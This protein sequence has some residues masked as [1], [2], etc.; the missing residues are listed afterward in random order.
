MFVGDYSI[1]WLYKYFIDHLKSQSKSLTSRGLNDLYSLH[2]HRPVSTGNLTNHVAKESQQQQSQ[3]PQ[4]HS[5]SLSATEELYED[6]KL[7]LK[8]IYIET[9]EMS[10]A[11]LERLKV[12]EDDVKEER[13]V[14][15]FGFTYREFMT[16][17]NV[18]DSLLKD[19]VYNLT[20]LL[21]TFDHLTA[22][23]SKVYWKLQDHIDE[24]NRPDM[25]KTLENR[26]IDM[27][28]AEARKILRYTDATIWEAAAMISSS[29]S[30]R[31]IDG[32]KLCELGLKHYTQL[33]WNMYCNDYMNY[34]D[35]SCCSSAEPYTLLQMVTYGFFGGR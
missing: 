25:W 10:D 28:N 24:Y 2:S 23:K 17:G 27:L 7:N 21:V 4:Q 16:N 22:R 15:V 11:L 26:N 31:A 1:H 14:F 5:S 30:D 13:N 9:N 35:G 6:H 34:N 12:F 19:Y 29:L 32:Y 20:R 33:L 3:Q 8:V 18:T